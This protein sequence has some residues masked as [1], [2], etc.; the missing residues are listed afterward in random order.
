DITAIRHSLALLSNGEILGLFPEGTRSK[1]GDMQEPF[2]GVA[3]LSDVSGAVIVPAA[4]HGK[5]KLFSKLR[6]VYGQPLTMSQLRPNENSSRELATK[7]L[8]SIIAELKGSIS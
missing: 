2:T 1:S 6:I 5:Y 4:I 3:M 8:M 7:R